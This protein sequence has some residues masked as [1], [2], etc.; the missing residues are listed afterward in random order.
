MK[1]QKTSKQ[2]SEDSQNRKSMQLYRKG[3][4]FH[5]QGCTRSM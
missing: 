3:N 4:L 5:Q 1:N 2:V